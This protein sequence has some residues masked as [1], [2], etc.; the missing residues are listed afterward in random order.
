MKKITRRRFMKS[1]L[2]VGAALTI[3]HARILGANNDI[4]VAIIG[5]GIK[6]GGHVKDFDRLS[7]VRVAAICDP[8]QKRVAAQAKYFQDQNKKIETYTDLRQILD[9]KKQY[10]R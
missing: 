9:D 5:L 2:A 6:G 1:S 4:C 10:G 8:D 3:P 7:G